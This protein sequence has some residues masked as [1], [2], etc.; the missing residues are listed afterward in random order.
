MSFKPFTRNALTLLPLLAMLPLTAACQTTAT[1]INAIESRI[2]ADVCSAW[3]P[4]TWSS[5]DTEQTQREVKASNLA[6]DVYCG[7]DKKEVCKRWPVV[8]ASGLDTE[9]VREKIKANNIA[10]ATYCGGTQW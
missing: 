4:V 2:A 5:R 10:R 7:M 1:R 6:R 9:I 3:Q 8:S